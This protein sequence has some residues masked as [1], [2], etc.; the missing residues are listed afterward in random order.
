MSGVGEEG[1]GGGGGAKL[2]RGHGG[3]VWGVCVL[4]AKD[5]GPQESGQEV[6]SLR[7]GKGH[8]QV[9]FVCCVGNGLATLPFSVHGN[10]CVV[11]KVDLLLLI[12]NRASFLSEAPS[13]RFGLLALEVPLEAF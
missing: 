3:H 5:R 10:V 1:E 2:F 4:S 8:A 7:R 13:F 12:A 11:P 9:A 6:P